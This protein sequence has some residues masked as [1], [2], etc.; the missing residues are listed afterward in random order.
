MIFE[1]I[2]GRGDRVDERRGADHSGEVP[3]ENLRPA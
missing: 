3:V 2:A 1:P